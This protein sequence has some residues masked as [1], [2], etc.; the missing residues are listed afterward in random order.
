MLLMKIRKSDLAA[1]FGRALLPLAR[2]WRAEG[3]RML[4][5]LGISHA[6]AWVLVEVGRLGD[7]V[8]Q[9]DLATRLDMRGP[10]LVELIDRLEAE[11]LLARQTDAQDRRKNYVIL[12]ES[13]RAMVGA[14]ETALDRVRLDLVSGVD[15]DDLETAW[16]VLDQII[17]SI[18]ERQS[19]SR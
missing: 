6:N 3:D 16:R 14:I 12:T 17:R 18:D 7:R 8:R 10:S 13:G 5:D 2:R 1:N 9:S 11:H 19:A 4:A 15:A